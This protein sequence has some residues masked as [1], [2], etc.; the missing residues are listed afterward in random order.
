MDP[1]VSGRLLFLM[2]GKGFPSRSLV[3]GRHV[4]PRAVST[5]IDLRDYHSVRLLA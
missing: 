5:R 4:H 2:H 3:K 1:L